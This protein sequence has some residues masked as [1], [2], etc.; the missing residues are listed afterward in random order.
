MNRFSRFFIDRPVFATVL[1]LLI[2][3]GGAVSILFLPVDRYPQIVPPSVQITTSYPGADAETVAESVATPIEQRLSAVPGLLYF[4]SQSGNDGSLSITATFEVGTNEDAAAVDVQNRLTG[5]YSRL[6]E[7]VIRRGIEVTK[8]SPGQLAII[9][10]ES[11]DPRYDDMF[12]SNYALVN[13]LNA[14]RREPGVG[15]ISIFG[16]RT[17]SMR[18]WIDPDRLTGIGMTLREVVSAIRDQNNLFPAGT[19]AARPTDEMVELTIPVQTSGRLNEPREYEQIIL[20]ALP[21][22]RMV[23]L[24][25]VARIEL[26]SNTYDR[27]GR[28]NERPTALMMV[29]KQ[30]DANA[31]D[32]MAN[33]RRAMDELA[34]SFPTGVRYHVPYDT[35]SFISASIREVVSTLIEAVILVILVVFSFLQSWRATLIPLLAIPVSIVGTFAGM[36]L[37]GFSINTLTLFGLVLA[38]GIVVDDAIVVVENVERL[39]KDEKLSPRDATIKAM[40]QVSGA[41]VAMVLV[42]CAVFVP[43]AFLGGMTGQLYRQF[44][45]T[46][47]VSV[48]ISGFVA[49]TLS[50]A[51]CRLI[52]RPS[53][54]HRPF[55]FF[56]WFNAGFER[57]TR[58]YTLGVRTLIRSSAVA[59]LLVIGFS[60]IAWRLAD[61][62]PTGFLPR[63]DQ[64]FFTAAVLLPDGASLDRTDRIL[65]DV[66]AFLRAHP[67]VENVI[68]LLGQDAMAGGIVSSNAAQLF[69]SLK[70]F[71]ERRGRDLHVQSVID[72]MTDEFR[73]VRDGMVYAFHPPAVQ[74]IGQRAGFQMEI[75]DRSGTSIAELVAAGEAFVAAAELRPELEGVSTSMRMQAP[76]LHVEV[77]RERAKVLGLNLA[78]VYDTLQTYLGTVYVNDF[79]MFGRVW[80]VNM[81]AQPR[82]RSDPAS[83]QSYFARSAEGRMIPLSAIV[84]TEF[85]SGP[86]LVE[87]FN[88]FNS[89]HISGAPA[90]GYGTGEAMRVLS[91]IA[92]EVLPAGFAYEWSGASY[93]E[94]RAASQAPIIMIFG[95]IVIF[96]VLAAQYERWLMPL[97][98]LMVVPF[99]IFGAL[100]AILLRGLT[101]DIYFQIGMLVLVGLAAKNA[102]LIVEFCA[103]QRREGKSAPDAAAEAARI[104][105][106]PILMTSLAF[107]AGV[108]PLAMASGAGAAARHSIGTGVIGGMLASTLLAP[109]FVPFF[110]VMLDRIAERL[111]VLRALFSDPAPE[112]D[113]LLR[114]GADLPRT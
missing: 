32:T 72:S 87:R 18:I 84:H 54:G 36:H 56:R 35:T 19:I 106:R 17:Y 93:Q 97:G 91:D 101:Q 11:D 92:Q 80:R 63:E 46:I 5:A 69:V 96:L 1:S 60:I 58:G 99:A 110:F 98:V 90:S 79:N 85:R 88:G 21:D 55:L 95:L 65:T 38:I 34:Q 83:I 57:L 45:V 9:A 29:S 33:V 113:R 68:A 94:V 39:M 42:L 81:Q 61:R 4:H 71:R 102:I 82:Y 44:A 109:F 76:R 51:L 25:D 23:R 6:P 50:P 2:L 40:R 12:L 47:A 53:S 15:N 111:K 64:G 74:G 52:L 3:L 7:E 67:A 30:V 103:A 27:V 43:I 48:A 104:R 100:T 14:I 22:G 28:V 89:V 37:L 49:L 16:S 78:E 75:Q 41:L 10:L 24:A 13:I 114:P 26:G 70:P 73:H 8:S 31:L 66:E 105:F 20:R 59:L 107:V 77:D 62:L 86:N 112:S 108:I